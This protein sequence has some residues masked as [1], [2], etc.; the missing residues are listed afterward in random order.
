M[1]LLWD[2]GFEEGWGGV[3]TGLAVLIP[4]LVRK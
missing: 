1:Q 3:A 2:P 4:P